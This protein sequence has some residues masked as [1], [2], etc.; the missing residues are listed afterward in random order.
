MLLVRSRRRDRAVLVVRMCAASRQR[1]MNRVRRRLWSKN[2]LLRRDQF[3]HMPLLRE[4]RENN[5]DDFRNFLRMSDP[6]FQQLLALVSP[7][8]TRQD[9]VMR[10]AITAEQRLVATLRY[11]AT[12]RSLQDLK[13]ST[14]ISPQSLG[15]IIPETCCAIIHVLQED[16]VKVSGVLSMPK[17]CL[18]CLLHFFNQKHS[19]INLFGIC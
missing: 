9:T 17:L 10:E 6:V 4:L 13:F 5:P 2:W 12:G 8:I 19:L 15:I 11:L 3:S 16:Y 14:G 7:Y 1:T 18:Y